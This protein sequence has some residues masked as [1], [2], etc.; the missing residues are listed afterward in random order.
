ML[1]GTIIIICHN[2]GNLFWE[3]ICVK[4]LTTQ[5]CAS[6]FR[7]LF[8]CKEVTVDNL[9]GTSIYAQVQ[10]PPEHLPFFFFFFSFALSPNELTVGC[11]AASRLRG[12]NRQRQPAT[13]YRIVSKGKITHIILIDLQVFQLLLLG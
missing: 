1:L 6:S 4:C 8:F 7:S 9:K 5:C 10:S 2:E 12:K 13:G 3:L 11:V